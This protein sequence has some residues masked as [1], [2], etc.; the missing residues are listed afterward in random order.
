MRTRAKKHFALLETQLRTHFLSPRAF[1]NCD[2]TLGLNSCQVNGWDGTARGVLLGFDNRPLPSGICEN[3]ALP[4]RVTARVVSWND[5]AGSR[6]L[7]LILDAPNVTMVRN[8][9][10]RI[11]IQIP[12][13]NL[14]DDVLRCPAASPRFLGFNSNGTPNCQPVQPCPAGSYAER[15]SADGS[16][17]VCMPFPSHD[18][19]CPAGSIISSF[20]WLGGNGAS[21]TPHACSPRIN[22]FNFFSM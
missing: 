1:S 3:P 12:V 16:Q 13:E 9:D 10:R 18:V 11:S 20:Q 2:S 17:M 19:T 7:V 6:M 22:P 5:P 8:A 15:L 4:C 14:Q 21:S